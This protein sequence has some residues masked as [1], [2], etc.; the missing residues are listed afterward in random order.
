MR[1]LIK[2]WITKTKE[3]VQ[4]HQREEEIKEWYRIVFGCNPEHIRWTDKSTVKAFSSIS[5]TDFYIL[6]LRV[7]EVKFSLESEKNSEYS[8]WEFFIEE[9]EEEEDTKIVYLWKKRVGK[10]KACVEIK[11]IK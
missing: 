4:Q 8:E 11:T 9:E 7:W 1:D 6:G 3:Q 5:Q 10:F 2:Y